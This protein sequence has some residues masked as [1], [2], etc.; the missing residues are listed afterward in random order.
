[1]KVSIDTLVALDDVDARA[2]RIF[3]E[4]FSSWSIILRGASD[5]GAIFGCASFV[6]WL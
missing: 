3:S 2:R 1:M 4:D 5:F 6:F